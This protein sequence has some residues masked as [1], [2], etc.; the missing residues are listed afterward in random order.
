MGDGPN[1]SAAASASLILP[2]RRAERAGCHSHPDTSTL[3]FFFGRPGLTPWLLF[4]LQPL[5]L[6]VLSL[7]QLL[8]LLLVALFELLLSRIISTLL[9]QPL[10]VLVLFLLQFLPLL[11]LLG[12]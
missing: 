12:L 3:G 6:P 5:H 8:R 10:V 11:L 4:L 7:L 9:R 2:R 1:S